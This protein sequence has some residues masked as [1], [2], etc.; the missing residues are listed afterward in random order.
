MADTSQTT[1]PS[2]STSVN[3]PSSTASSPLLSAQPT[4]AT[5]I[6]TPDSLKECIKCHSVSYCN[7]DCQKAHFKV[8]KKVCAGLAQEYSKHN[9]PKMARSTVST[10]AARDRGLQKWQFDT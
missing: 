1:E 6:K 2:S 10:K 3:Q 9:E 7:K 4:C 5:C 8:H